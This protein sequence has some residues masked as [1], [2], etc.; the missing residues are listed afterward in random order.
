[1]AVFID[2]AGPHREEAPEPTGSRQQ[3]RLHVRGH[4][5]V[6]DLREQL[7]ARF[8]IAALRPPGGIPQPSVRQRAREHVGRHDEAFRN[9]QLGPQQATEL[10][11]LAAYAGSVGWR[12]VGEGGKHGSV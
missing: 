8:G 5:Q 1:M 9:R 4:L 3:L 12:E 11:G 10:R 7:G 6:W 2:P